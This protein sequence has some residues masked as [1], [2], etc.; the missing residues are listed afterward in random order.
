M[1]RHEWNTRTVDGIRRSVALAR[2]ATLRDPGHGASHAMLALAGV[3]LASYL[4]EP[5]QGPIEL[6]REAATRAIE[7]DERLGD[8]HTALGL[9]HLGYDWRWEEA[10]RALRRATTLAPQHATAWSWLGFLHLSRGNLEQAL[11]DTRRAELLDPASLIIKSQVARV[12]YFSGRHEEAL[13]HLEETLAIDRSF[14]RAYMNAAWCHMAIGRTD[15]AV[16]ALETAV[17]LNDYPLLR[18]VLASAYARAGREPE[19]RAAL[20]DLASSDRHLSSYILVHAR[21]AL[22]EI[23]E[24][25]RLLTRACDD[26]EWLLIFVRVD[27]GVDELR[28]HPV[29]REV[30]DRIAFSVDRR[31]TETR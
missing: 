1:A 11:V 28:T 22:G 23:D 31:H 30:V 12:L 17:A 5:M 8:A 9:I 26:R 16:H 29:Y 7:I 24:A 4:S 15:E 2:Q 6:A 20:A 18:T 19:A 25:A 21:L 13:G 27:P 14:W 10:E 3:V